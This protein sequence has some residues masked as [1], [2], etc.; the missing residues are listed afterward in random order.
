MTKL[1]LAFCLC[2]CATFINAQTCMPDMQYADST[3]GVYPKPYDA[4]TNT[5]VGITECAVIGQNFN[6]N[7]TVV[8]HDSLT[9]GT[10]SY[11]LDSI[12]ISSVEGLPT[13]LTYKCD[14]ANCHFVQNTIS[15]AAIYGIPTAANAPGAYDMV[16]KGSAYINGSS[17][18]LPLEFP[19]PLIAPGKY[20][21]HLNANSSDPC[22]LTATKNLEGQMSITTQPNP[23]AGMVQIKINSQINGQFQMQVLDLLGK[24]IAQRQVSISAGVNSLEYDASGLANG[25]YLMQIQNEQGFVTQK[26][27]VQH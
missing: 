25:L 12:V 15:C 26:L 20:T 10:S 4:A 27:A 9:I 1:L 2:A 19:N 3:A 16:I 7:L 23:T 22:S 8:I 13:G 6:V 17:F 5:G 21:I 24:R 14:P 18:P 11:P